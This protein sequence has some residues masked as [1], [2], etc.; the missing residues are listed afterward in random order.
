MATF[1]LHCRL[2]MVISNYHHLEKHQ[3]SRQDS[4]NATQAE[5]GEAG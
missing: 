4:I 1:L 5:F 3:A 2:L